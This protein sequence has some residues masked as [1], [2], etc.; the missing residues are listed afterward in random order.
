MVTNFYTETQPDLEPIVTLAMA[1][2]QL[3]VDAD[4][5]EEDDLIVDY[6]DAA[7]VACQ[8]FIN[9]SIAL[10]TLTLE[11]DAFEALVTFAQNYENDTIE[12][13]EYYAPGEETLTVLDPA[14]YQL[15]KST[16]LEC[17]DIKFLELPETDERSDAVIIS[18][19]QGFDAD[20]IPATIVQAIK[21]RI[22]AFYDYREDRPQG[23]DTTS[24]NLLRAYRNY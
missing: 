10:Q 8:N 15:R 12:K 1:K 4:F 6:S 20:S 17:K 14:K 2:K 18:I 22:S 3:R 19:I 16:V 13:V 5:T 9:R 7:Q 21:L 23:F 11:L 24:N